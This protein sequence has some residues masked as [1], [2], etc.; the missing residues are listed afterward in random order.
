MKRRETITKEWSKSK[1]G[2]TPFEGFE[3]T[4]WPVGTIIR[5]KSV[6]REGEITQFSGGKPVRF[7]ETLVR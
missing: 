3:A 1:C 7:V 4:A 6:M 2:W 5:G